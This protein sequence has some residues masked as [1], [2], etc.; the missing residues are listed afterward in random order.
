MGVQTG[1][2][3]SKLQFFRKEENWGDSNQMEEDFLLKLDRYRSTLSCL[4]Q[5]LC[6]YEESG[7]APNSYH[8]MGQ[9]VD[10]RFFDAI[11]HKALSPLDHFLTA[12]RSP[13]GGVGIYLWPNHDPFVHLDSRYPM[14][15]RKIWVSEAP[16]VYRNIDQAFVEHLV[17]SSIPQG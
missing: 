8:Y 5:I 2:I 10:C 13:F 4:C 1:D 15:D 16:K 9:A 3:W 14:R 17:K 6:G 7:H 12:I 11:T